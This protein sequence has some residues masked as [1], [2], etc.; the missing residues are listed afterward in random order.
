[1]YSLRSSKSRDKDND[2]YEID[3][4]DL[5]NNDLIRLV[6]SDII[7]TTMTELN[8]KVSSLQEEVITLR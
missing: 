1:M 8:E 4:T 7:R 5:L 3:L 6:L 2:A